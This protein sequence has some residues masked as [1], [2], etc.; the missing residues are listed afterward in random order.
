MFVA[1][2]C[3]NHGVSNN[4]LNF[5]ISFSFALS[6]QFTPVLYLSLHTT[7]THS[8]TYLSPWGQCA[9]ER[10]A[11]RGWSFLEEVRLQTVSYSSEAVLYLRRAGAE[12]TLKGKPPIP[13]S[14]FLSQR[15]KIRQVWGTQFSG[16]STSYTRMRISVHTL[17]THINVMQAQWVSLIPAHR[18]QTVRRKLAS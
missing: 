8:S 7:S 5:F 11:G 9:P 15:Q 1:S 2:T 4:S 13:L 17:R 10:S 12:F 16:Y 3:H 14:C 6:I 18:R